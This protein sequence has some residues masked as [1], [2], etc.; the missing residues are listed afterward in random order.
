MTLKYKCP[1]C[2]KSSYSA[3]TKKLVALP[4]GLP[5]LGIFQSV[6]VMIKPI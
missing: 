2:G 6:K 1:Y 4:A 5:L 3:S